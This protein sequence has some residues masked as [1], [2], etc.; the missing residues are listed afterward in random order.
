[1]SVFSGARDASVEAPARRPLGARIRSRDEK[2]RPS[3]LLLW[4]EPVID[5][6]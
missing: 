2:V 1:M 4:F 5:S 3:P 6:E